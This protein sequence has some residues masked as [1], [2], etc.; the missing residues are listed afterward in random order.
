MKFGQRSDIRQEFYRLATV[1]FG[2]TERLYSENNL[3]EKYTQSVYIFYWKEL[4]ATR[5]RNIFKQ[6]LYNLFFIDHRCKKEKIY[7]AF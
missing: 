3:V 5:N 6:K 2:G 1:A 4:S 7:R